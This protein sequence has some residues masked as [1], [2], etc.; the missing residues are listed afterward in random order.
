MSKSIFDIKLLDLSTKKTI[1][2][3]PKQSN[4]KLFK[5]QNESEKPE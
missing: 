1:A 5:T 2:V 4:K 3:K